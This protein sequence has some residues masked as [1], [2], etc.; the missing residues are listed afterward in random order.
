ML[1]LS[2]TVYLSY[3]Y[4]LIAFIESTI[5][6]I[7]KNKSD[8]LSD[9][10]NYGSSSI[11]QAA[12]HYFLNSKVCS[13]DKCNKYLISSDIQIGFKSCHNTD[14]CIYAPKELIVYYKNK[15]TTVYITLLNS[16]KALMD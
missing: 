16:S 14:L 6:P 10:N 8:N 12:I 5:V 9:S 4:L 3:V 11:A 1:A 2:F 7:T 15:E 13:I